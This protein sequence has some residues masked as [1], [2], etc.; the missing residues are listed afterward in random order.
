M[1]L[2]MDL[3]ELLGSLTEGAG[4]GMSATDTALLDS[5]A[6]EGIAMDIRGDLERGQLYFRFGGDFMTTALGVDEN[7]WFSMDMARMYEAM[8]MDYSGLLSMAAG[9]V[10]YSGLLSALLALA[11]T[12]PTDKDTAYSDLSAAVDLAAQLLRDDAWTA[13]GNDRILHYSLEQ[14]GAAAELTFTLTLDGEDVAAYSVDVS[15]LYIDPDTGMATALTLYDAM[16]GDDR[17]AGFLSLMV[18]DLLTFDIRMTGTYT[19]GDAAPETQPP[20]G[21]AVVDLLEMGT[22]VPEAQPAE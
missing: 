12:E 8:G 18:G 17:M 2:R 21:A 9:D 19:P 11:V 4:G 16:G 7:T 3:Q 15:L 14:G 1:A 10:D 13:S 20:E 22:A 6:D 5:L